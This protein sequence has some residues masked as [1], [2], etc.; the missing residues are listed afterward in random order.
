MLLWISGGSAASPDTQPGNR[1][2]NAAPKAEFQNANGLKFC[3]IYWQ[4]HHPLQV[5]SSS[6]H[7]NPPRPKNFIEQILGVIICNFLK[8]GS[9]IE[10]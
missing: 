7:S 10:A 1:R 4:K 5:S 3:V 6:L 9:F 8:D 2:V